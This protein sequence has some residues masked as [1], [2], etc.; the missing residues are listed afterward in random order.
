LIVNQ[1]PGLAPPDDLLDPLADVSLPDLTPLDRVEFRIGEVPGWL[2]GQ[3][4]GSPR[5]QFWMR[6]K[7]GRDADPLSLALLVDAFAPAVVEIGA[8]STTVQL[9]IHVRRRPAPGW[10]ACRVESRYVFGGYHE[11]D[12][13]IWD[14]GGR[15]VA[16]SRQLGLVRTSTLHAAGN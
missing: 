8:L 3:P 7:D 14:S 4:S 2:K 15:L 6:F 11:E 10:L 9:T 16:Q 12:F 5:S 13:E 1:P